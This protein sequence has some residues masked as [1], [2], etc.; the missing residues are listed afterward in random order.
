MRIF[1][2]DEDK[3]KRFSK[4]EK[5]IVAC[6]VSIHFHEDNAGYLFYGCLPYFPKLKPCFNIST[7]YILPTHYFIISIKQKS[8]HFYIYK[9][10]TWLTGFCSHYLCTPRIFHKQ[11][12]DLNLKP[13]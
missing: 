9:H 4:R 8:T 10:H 6:G 7:S 11:T 1:W 13:C 2:T 3:M 12:W 5:K